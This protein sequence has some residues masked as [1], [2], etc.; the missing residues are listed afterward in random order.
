M[1]GLGLEIAFIHMFCSRR[2]ESNSVGKKNNYKANWERHVIFDTLPK[3]E[4]QKTIKNSKR[5][6]I[7]NM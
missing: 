7:I 4:Y 1:K 2:F 3:E 5:F 6:S